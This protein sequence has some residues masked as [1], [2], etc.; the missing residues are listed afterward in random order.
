MHHPNNPMDSPK[1]NPLQNPYH[2]TYAVVSKRFHFDAAHFLPEYIGKCSRMH[3]HRWE[4][5][6]RL[7][8]R[9]DSKSQMVMDFKVIDTIVEVQVLDELDHTVLNETDDLYPTAEMISEWIYAKLRPHFDRDLAM[10]IR[11]Y[12]S[13][14]SWAQYSGNTIDT[15]A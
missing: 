7:S 2:P 8:G 13:P 5:E 9:V 1:G 10:K 4:F 14:D 15:W 11:V 3:G 6:V 12:E